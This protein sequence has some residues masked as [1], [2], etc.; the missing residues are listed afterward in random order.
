MQ[1][2]KVY[3]HSFQTARNSFTSKAGL[4]LLSSERA[5][6]MF[7]AIIILELILLSRADAG[8]THTSAEISSYTWNRT[9]TMEVTFK[10]C[11]GW[12]KLWFIYVM[13]PGPEPGHIGTIPMPVF[14]PEHLT[15]SLEE[16]VLTL[17]WQVQSSKGKVQLPVSHTLD[18]GRWYRA[19]LW[20]EDFRELIV[21]SLAYH[22]YEETILGQV[23]VATS[24]FNRNLFY[25]SM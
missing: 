5:S 2:S 11:T 7:F 23:L 13:L 3:P 4:F 24:T 20:Y 22:D 12:G 15:L 8:L 25:F 19:R 9:K 10:T 18:D 14:N 21:L 1:R 6:A 17:S 16:G